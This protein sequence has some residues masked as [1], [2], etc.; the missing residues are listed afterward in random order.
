MVVAYSNCGGLSVLIGC[1]CYYLKS[2]PSCWLPWRSW[3]RS[4]SNCSTRTRLGLNQPGWLLG[5][6]TQ[7]TT[8]KR[9]T[10]LSFVFASVIIIIIITT[11]NMSTMLLPVDPTIRYTRAVEMWKE[12]MRILHKMLCEHST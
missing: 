2:L 5:L 12:G 11:N 4:R 7:G 9:T 10:S 8:Q 3:A 1:H 6:Q